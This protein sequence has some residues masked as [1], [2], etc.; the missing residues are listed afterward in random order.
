MTDTRGA[1]TVRDL[2]YKR[3]YADKAKWRIPN[4]NFEN[5]TQTSPRA[6]NK[7]DAKRFSVFRRELQTNVKNFLIF[8]KFQKFDNSDA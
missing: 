6:F 5:K 2:L 8:L 3:A 7:N 4:L 1:Q